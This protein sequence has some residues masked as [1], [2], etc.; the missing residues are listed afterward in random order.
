MRTTKKVNQILTSANQ[1]SEVDV[2]IR[3]ELKIQ[4]TLNWMSTFA[5][6]FSETMSLMLTSIIQKKT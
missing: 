1:I 5:T 6:H 3:N 2:N 4:K